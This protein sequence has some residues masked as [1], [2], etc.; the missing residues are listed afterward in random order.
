MKLCFA[1]DIK[2]VNIQDALSWEMCR[3]HYHQSLKGTWR[4]RIVHLIICIA[5]APPV[6]GQIAS[7]FELGIIKFFSFLESH[8]SKYVSS[9][10]R[11]DI[12][13]NQ[14]SESDCCRCWPSDLSL[15]GISKK[16]KNI[17]D[18]HVREAFK[19][20]SIT[21]K[22]KMLSY[23]NAINS[24]S[25]YKRL[26]V[27]LAVIQ[28][29][30]NRQFLLLPKTVFKSGGERKIRWAYNLSTGDFLLKKRIVGCFE[31]QI[32]K[33]L[34]QNRE[35]RGIKTSVEWR[36]SFDKNNNVKKQVIEPLREGIT[37]VLFGK[38]PLKKFSTKREI[39]LDFLKDLEALHK[40][41]IQD[42]TVPSARV[43]IPGYRAFH[44]DIKIDNT[45]VFQENGK[46]RGELCD[47]GGSTANPTAF[48]LSHGY[49]P[50]EFIR[51]YKDVKPFGLHK[52]CF[53]ENKNI[54]FNLKYGQRRDVWS[55]GLVILSVLVGKTKN[56]SWVTETMN[57][58]KW[59]NVRTSHKSVIPP[60]ACLKKCVTPK[61]KE[62]YNEIGILKLSQ[63]SLDKE[64]DQL[65]E[66]VK[67]QHKDD[68]SSVD[69]LFKAVKQM[70]RINPEE[71]ASVAAI[72]QKINS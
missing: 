35:K 52:T 68:K 26:P 41:T 44:S 28:E 46:W 14:E 7:L 71:R 70:L 8:S 2:E 24:A 12:I 23:K 16:E 31:E 29:N 45:L 37:S 34:H 10:P 13:K 9:R 27:S 72:L 57:L 51:H 59:V 1:V 60:L 62:K 30:S 40:I 65:C 3:N 17:I 20:S 67:L 5:E 32:I 42:V 58:E 6:I 54:E 22:N 39:I 33:L 36:N 25:V 61:N 69:V 55:L 43:R 4:G 50:P 47:F 56:V 66:E 48:T 49:T 19:A 63:Q 11:F 53:N 64:I 21:C 38:E 15:L 18:K